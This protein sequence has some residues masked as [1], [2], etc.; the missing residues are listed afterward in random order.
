MRLV[1]KDLCGANIPSIH[2]P[3]KPV[4]KGGRRTKGWKLEPDEVPVRKKA[5]IFNS[6]GD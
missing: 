3:F 6:E 1:Y 5:P 4:E 2:G